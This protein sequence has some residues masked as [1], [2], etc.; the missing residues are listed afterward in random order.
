[1]QFDNNINLLWATG[2]GPSYLLNPGDYVAH[3]AY[4]QDLNFDQDHNLLVTGSTND[5]F[6]TTTFPYNITQPSSAYTQGHTAGTGFYNAFIA[7]LNVFSAVVYGLDYY[8]EIGGSQQ[9]FGDAIISDNS[10]NIYVGGQ[11]NSTTGFPFKNFGGGALYINSFTSGQFANGFISMF[12]PNGIQD[13][14][15]LT[16]GGY[17]VNS[18]AIDNLSNLY[19]FGYT[20]GAIELPTSNSSPYTYLDNGAPFGG[21]NKSFIQAFTSSHILDWGTYFGGTSSN[22]TPNTVAGNCKIGYIYDYWGNESSAELYICGATNTTDFPILNA[23]FQPFGIYGQSFGGNENAYI[24][25]F[26]ISGGVII[27]GIHAIES[28]NSNKINLYPNPNLGSFLLQ[29][30]SPFNGNADIQVANYLG[31]TVYEG[32]TTNSTMNICLNN[33]NNGIYIIHVSVNESSY[34]IK[35]IKE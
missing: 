4:V 31:Q 32:A 28:T 2:I 13:W 8:S 26:T 18:M 9:S 3:G 17:S 6:P 19:C 25:G 12:D 23:Q 33:L 10:G 16:G 1:M 5:A 35:F 7:K 21:N 27:P 11:T 15:T 24:A 34:S 20:Y 14:T 22:N 29:F 30:E